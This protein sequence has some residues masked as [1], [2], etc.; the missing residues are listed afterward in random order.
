MKKVTQAILVGILISV[1]SF[2]ILQVIAYVFYPQSAL[3]QT[4]KHIVNT[5]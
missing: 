1:A 2:D 3:A 4:L 5:I